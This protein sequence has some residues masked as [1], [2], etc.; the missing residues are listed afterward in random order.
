M[1]NVIALAAGM[2]DGM[3][4]G[5]NTKAA[6]DDPR[7]CWRSARLGVELGGKMETFCGLSGIGDL[8]R[9]LYQ[10]PTAAIITAVIC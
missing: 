1:K 10:A 7:N 5:D 3:G 6:L 4:L 9:N 8:D 2:L